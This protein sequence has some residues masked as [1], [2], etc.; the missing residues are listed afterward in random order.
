MKII[1]IEKSSFIDYP[2]KIST[3]LFTK[4]CNF[5][6]PYCHNSSIVRGEEE[7]INIEEVLDYIESRKK[8]IDAICV[9]G[10]E[11]TLHDG[12]YEFIKKLKDKG[13]LVKLDTNGSRPS[14]VERLLREKL[15]DYIAMDIK[16]P[17]EKY[18]SVTKV[19]VDLDKISQSIGLIRGASIGYEFRT[20][21]C[22]ELLS[23][24]DLLEIGDLLA[25]SKAYYLQN[26]QDSGNVL[27]GE[28]KLHPYDQ[29][30]LKF[31]KRQIQGNFN[32][33]KIR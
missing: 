11:P 20:T 7:E 33:C 16:A 25:R 22:K 2:D 6:C 15:L 19:K 9:S 31:I 28:G 26:F 27:I 21:V 10:G 5:R 32:L 3:V 14:V 8:F 13:F 17:L 1:G 24:R 12:L 29:E 18:D 4:G 23:T 30:K